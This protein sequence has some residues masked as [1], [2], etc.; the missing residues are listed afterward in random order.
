MIVAG[1]VLAAGRSSRF[2]GGNKLL[3]T[4]GERSVAGHC[5][6][7]MM[8]AGVTCRAV[9]TTDPQ[10]AALFDGFELLSPDG[11]SG[12]Q[13]ASLRAAVAWA[14]A[15][16]AD[17]LVVSLADMPLVDVTLIDRV[18]ARCE[19]DQASV[20]GAG[21]RR[22][23]PACFPK[24][25][26]AELARASGDRGARTMLLSLPPDAVVP[27]S[28]LQLTDIDTRGDLQKLAEDALA[29][30]APGV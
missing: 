18:I 16:G 24:A 17:R 23:P 22:A 26:F 29:R 25:A 13:S 11:S 8:L 9:V 2:E 10:V 21:D 28:D 3:A 12:D 15:K 6:A 7:A 30:D 4:M 19:A 1:V 5:A 14:A 27:A 20:A